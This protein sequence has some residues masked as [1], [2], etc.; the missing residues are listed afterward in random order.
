MKRS[1]TLWATVQTCQQ[2]VVLVFNLSALF[3][4]CMQEATNTEELNESE[5]GGYDRHAYQPPDLSSGLFLREDTTNKAKFAC[6]S[7]NAQFWDIQTCRK[8]FFYYTF[9]YLHNFNTQCTEPENST[10]VAFTY[11]NLH[12]F[13]PIYILQVFRGVVYIIHLILFIMLLLK[14]WWKCCF[15]Y[16]WL[17]TIFSDLFIFWFM[18]DKKKSSPK[19]PL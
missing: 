9:I 17:L 13:I 7:R 6:F 16:P 4:G 15:F 8:C 5:C 12:S 2:P 18:C 19:S 11:T 3:Q 14:T 1:E 10:S